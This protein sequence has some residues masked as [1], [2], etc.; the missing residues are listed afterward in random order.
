MF[1]ITVFFFMEIWKLCCDEIALV[2]MHIGQKLPLNCNNWP[3]LA[4]EEVPVV[5][6]YIYVA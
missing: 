3:K 2:K 6:V 1:V 5:D 4:E